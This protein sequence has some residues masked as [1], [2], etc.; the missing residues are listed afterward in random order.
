MTTTRADILERHDARQDVP[1]I[2]EAL[3]VT[4]GYVYGVLRDER[5]DRL[6]GN[7]GRR[8]SDLRGMILGLQ[9]QGIKP[10]RIAFLMQKKCTRQYVYRIISEAD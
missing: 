5:P 7:R 3:G 9:A 10:A 6:H 2:A 4:P 8:T 1:T